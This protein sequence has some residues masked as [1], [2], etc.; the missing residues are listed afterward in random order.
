MDEIGDVARP[1]IADVLRQGRRSALAG[2]SH[3]LAFL[4]QMATPRGPV[5]AYVHG[6]AGIGKT[7]LLSALA[8]DFD[9]DGIRNVRIQAG[10]VEPRA[11]AIVMALGFTIEYQPVINALA[12]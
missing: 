6:P 7:S 9:A 8:A 11:T 12:H 1:T 3:E 10:A 4:R 2:R 5:V